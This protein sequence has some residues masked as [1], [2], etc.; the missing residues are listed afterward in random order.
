MVVEPYCSQIWVSALAGPATTKEVIV[1]A[2]SSA[3]AVTARMRRLM[4]APGGGGCP[5]EGRW[6]RSHATYNTFIGVRSVAA[7]FGKLSSAI[8]AADRQ[9]PPARDGRGEYHG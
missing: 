5:G 1:P 9:R 7:S 2:A 4:T 8:A 3:A 6:E